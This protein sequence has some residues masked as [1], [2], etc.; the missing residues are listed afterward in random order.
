MGVLLLAGQAH[1]IAQ[2][3]GVVL[4]AINLRWRSPDR[5][6]RTQRLR[7]IPSTWIQYAHRLLDTQSAGAEIAVVL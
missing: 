2:S 4:T 3:H 1:I 7:L 5:V 6:S